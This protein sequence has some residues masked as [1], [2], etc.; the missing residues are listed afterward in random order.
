[1]QIGRFAR[2]TEDKLHEK[3]VTFRLGDPPRD[4]RI[5]QHCHMHA[6]E[7]EQQFILDCHCT[8]PTTIVVCLAMTTCKVALTSCGAQC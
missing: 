8:Q 6:V 1:M 2:L 4:E 7:D 5:C 3:T